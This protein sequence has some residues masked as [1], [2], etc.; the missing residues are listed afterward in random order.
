[1]RCD[2]VASLLHNPPLLFLDEPTIGLDVVAKDR[3]REFL[4]EIN[5]TQRTTVLLTTHDLSDIEELCKRLLIIDKGKIL[6]D[7]E[8][9]EMKQ[10]LAKFNQVKFF[11]KDR[12][13]VARL[14]RFD[15]EQHSSAEV[16]RNLVNTLEVRDIL[17]EEEPIE[18]IV[19]R[20][21]LSG[22]VA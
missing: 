14:M 1:M 22:E 18:D 8:L 5:R 11:L 2:L 19:K 4:K 21:Y 20:I 12:A 13:Q 15:R 17:V 9:R 3:I 16:I 6:F 7:S 10:R